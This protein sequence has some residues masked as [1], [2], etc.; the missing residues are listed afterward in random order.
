MFVTSTVTMVVARARTRSGLH[1]AVGADEEDAGSRA[2]GRARMP[3]TASA[4]LMWPAV[5]PQVKRKFIAMPP[6]IK[7]AEIWQSA[8][9][10]RPRAAGYTLQ[11]QILARFFRR[12][13]ARYAQNNAHFTELHEQRRAAIAEKR[14]RNARTR[15]EVRDDRDVQKHLDRQQR[16]DADADEEAVA[17][18]RMRGDPVAA[19]DE[20]RKQDQDRDGADIAKLLTTDGKDVVI[21]LLR[22]VEVF[23]PA[24]PRPSP[25]K[26]PEPMEYS[27]CTI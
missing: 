11:S 12:N 24:L 19:A 15:D 23:L 14:Q 10:G 7:K 13:V 5:P 2:S 4:G 27:D 22:Q 3:P 20:Q 18:G 25:R 16:R 9:E 26:P 17:V 6:R 21:V 8:P 1:L